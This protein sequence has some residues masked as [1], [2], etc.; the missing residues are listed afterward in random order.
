MNASAAR[1]VHRRAAYVSFRC[2]AHHRRARIANGP[3]AKSSALA[4]TA[5]R[6]RAKAS[7][8][9]IS[10]APRLPRRRIRFNVVRSSAARTHHESLLL[11]ILSCGVAPLW[12]AARFED[13]LFNPFSILT[14]SRT[15]PTA[16]RPSTTSDATK[17]ALPPLPH[18]DEK[19]VAS[20]YANPTPEPRPTIVAMARPTLSR[21]AWSC[22]V[23]SHGP[24]EMLCILLYS[25]MGSS[26]GQDC[27]EVGLHA[28]AIW[29]RVQ[30][31]SRFVELEPRPL[32]C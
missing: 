16:A 13:Q 12:T 10:H 17:A 23:E 19:Q 30:R 2:R 4:S 14:K 32:N 3:R 9:L 15:T 5:L 8:T 29:P 24:P 31:P 28:A 26:V 1:V 11:A 22:L 27:D 21:S 18:Q 7:V 20:A 25:K 6:E